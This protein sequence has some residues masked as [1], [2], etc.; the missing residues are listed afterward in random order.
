MIYI[1]IECK[2][3]VESRRAGGDEDFREVNAQP[4]YWKVN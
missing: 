4:S 1:V 2:Q 3:L